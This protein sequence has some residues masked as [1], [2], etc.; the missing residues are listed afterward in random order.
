MLKI[1]V[2]NN[3]KKYQPIIFIGLYLS[4]IIGFFLGENSTGGAIIDYNTHKWISQKFA[5]NFLNTLF[6]YDS[7]NTRH[8][9][10]LIIF[11]SFFEKLNINDQ[12]IRLIH[13]H[14]CLLLPYVFFKC[15]QLNFKSLDKNIL[16]F[17][18][19]LIFLSPTFRSLSIW[20]D[21]RIIGLTF[22]LISIF[23]FLKF[24]ENKKFE[25]VIKNIFYLSLSSY[26]SPNF[27][28]FSIFYFINYMNNYNI[29]S[30]KFLIIILL[31]ILLSIPA[32]YYIFFLDINFLIKSAAIGRT[33]GNI[34][35]D[36]IFND[37]LI[38]FSIIFFYIFPFLITKIIKPAK[39]FE[40]KNFFISSIIFII[41]ILNFDYNFEYSGG[42]IFLKFSNIFFESNFVFFIISF[43]SIIILIPLLYQN[44]S[45][46][47]LFV[48]IILNNPQYTIYHKYFD[49]FLLIVF[50]TIFIFKYDFKKTFQ[51]NENYIFIYFYFSLFLLISNLKYIWIN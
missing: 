39:I 19:S 36:N 13:L 18:I 34:I 3:I 33:S 6:S 8:S 40:I 4:L 20:P 10:I 11:L 26:I 38:T 49:P 9:P 25:Y 30:Q 15:L 27:S 44:K 5:E 45:N 16:L 2:N 41:C 46:I 22:F 12:I 50:F 24:K 14:F 43:L 32:I 42:G 23:Y 35:F 29:F 28:V 1:D 37:I 47:L 7:Y 48:L 17:F 31:N 51:K 21:S